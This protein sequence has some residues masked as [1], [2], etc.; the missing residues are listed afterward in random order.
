MQCFYSKGGSG[1]WATQWMNSLTGAFNCEACALQ[2]L[3]WASASTFILCTFPVSLH[4]HNQLIQPV[5]PI[6]TSALSLSV[7]LQPACEASFLD[8]HEH[9]YLLPHSVLL[10][11][12][13]PRHDSQSESSLSVIV[14]CPLARRPTC[15]LA[16][17]PAL[18]CR[19]HRRA[20]LLRLRNQAHL[21][22]VSS[23]THSAA[24]AL[25]S[26]L[27]AGSSH[28]CSRRS[29]LTFPSVRHTRLFLFAQFDHQP[30]SLFFLSLF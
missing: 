12:P 17:P 15:L 30:T 9:I 28:C 19:F 20:H 14:C 3:E 2:S 10:N 29:L 18:C 6:V 13:Q 22:I 5:H 4:L 24:A 16:P 23:S 21:V 1:C 27:P 25:W 26:S 11:L 8:S 7:P